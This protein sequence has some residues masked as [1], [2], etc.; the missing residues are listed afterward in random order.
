MDKKIV[1]AQM[2]ERKKIIE[3]KNRKGCQG[4]L[5]RLARQIRNLEKEIGQV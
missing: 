2:I 4:V 5:K 3:N 1:L